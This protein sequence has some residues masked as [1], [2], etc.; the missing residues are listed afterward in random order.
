MKYNFAQLAFSAIR[1]QS[2]LQN[3]ISN[4]TPYLDQSTKTQDINEYIDGF[5][6][7]AMQVSIEA[8]DLA[9]LL[10]QYSDLVPKASKQD[11]EKWIQVGSYLSDIIETYRDTAHSQSQIYTFLSVEKGSKIQEMS[12][13]E[14]T[15][16]VQTVIDA[17]GTVVALAGEIQSSQVGNKSKIEIFTT[18][19][20][21][22]AQIILSKPGKKNLVLKA[23]T[24][25]QGKV[26]LELSKSYIGYTAK[27]L[28]DGKL[29]DSEKLSKK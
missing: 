24:D 1:W 17:G 27:A 5:R 2:E 12:L 13:I 29:L 28:V 15:K 23:E 19:P 6:T 26:E 20:N 14:K 3:V 4:P 11:A 21:E 7:S 8:N 9:K 16:D 22:D 18:Q 25:A 10:P